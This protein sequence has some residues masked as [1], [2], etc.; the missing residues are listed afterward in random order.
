MLIYYLD[1][2]NE[3]KDNIVTLRTH[4]ILN[5]PFKVTVSMFEILPNFL[6]LFQCFLT[7]IFLYFVEYK[8]LFANIRVHDSS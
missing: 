3:N 5:D 2:N 1:L 4:L 7:D 8:T 6:T